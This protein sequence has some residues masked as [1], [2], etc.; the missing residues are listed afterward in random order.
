M[1]SFHVA[2][3][4]TTMSKCEIQCFSQL[5]L[6][7]NTATECGPE[8]SQTAAHGCILLI[9]SRLLLGSSVGRVLYD[10]QAG[11]T[12]GVW[13]RVGLVH[14]AAQYVGTQ[15]G[16]ATIT[17]ILLSLG[18][19][20]IYHYNSLRL[21]SLGRFLLV[22]MVHHMY[23]LSRR[24]LARGWVL[25]PSLGVVRVVSRLGGTLGVVWRGLLAGH[26]PGWAQM[27]WENP[28]LLLISKKLEGMYPSHIKYKCAYNKNQCLQG[29]IQI[30]LFN[31][32]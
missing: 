27:Q 10:K 22:V 13:M 7:K 25:A 21:L 30:F 17:V 5:I 15:A 16:T 24:V 3:D 8:T 29:N 1:W 28:L 18:R 11:C 32:Q 14:T 9:F 4:S 20:V 12:L 23:W 31:V 26:P 19:I 6:V 2:Q